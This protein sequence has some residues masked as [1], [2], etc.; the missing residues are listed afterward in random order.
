MRGSVKAELFTPVHE[1][2]TS[3]AR[4]FLSA[5]ICNSQQALDC[6]GVVELSVIAADRNV[7]A[8][9]NGMLYKPRFLVYL[10]WQCMVRETTESGLDWRLWSCPAGIP[11]AALRLK[12]FLPRARMQPGHRL[13]D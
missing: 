3:G 9:Q 8:P 5:A 2:F 11:V 6:P 13:P 1:L 10:N 7:R 12:G 4:T